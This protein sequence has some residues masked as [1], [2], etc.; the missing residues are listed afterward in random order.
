MP[1]RLAASLPPPPLSRA[2]ADGA[3]QSA[4]QYAA[5]HALVFLHDLLPP[6]A[7]AAAARPA[8]KTPAGKTPAGKTHTPTP[9]TPTPKTPTRAP[10]SPAPAADGGADSDDAAS[11]FKRVS[12]LAVRLGH[13]APA[14]HI[15]PEP[16]MANFFRGR[17]VF[18]SAGAPPAGV[19]A[20][21]AVLGKRETRLL[22]AEGAL[23]WLQQQERR[24]N[25]LVQS[26]WATAP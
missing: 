3:A 25:E 15:E 2:A 8:P 13:D 24:R 18:R 16:D 6:V 23:A 26:L 10:P 19:G 14:Y 17:A 1:P 4:K 11:V 22:V 9:K 7:A 12:D 20:V 5:K 21:N